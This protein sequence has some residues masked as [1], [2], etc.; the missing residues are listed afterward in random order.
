MLPKVNLLRK[1]K[2]F[3][4]VF[5]KNRSFNGSILGMKVRTN[6]NETIR[7]GFLVGLKVSKRA[8]KRNLVKRR[9]KY[10]IGQHLFEIR[11]GQ[12]FVLIGFPLILNK[13][14]QE[15]AKEIDEGLVK[16]KAL[17]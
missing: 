5:E 7:F 11:P 1:E 13:S 17:L 15:I 14:Y 16:L 9:M 6:Q 8:C 3:A 12:D 10:A 4:A 2:D